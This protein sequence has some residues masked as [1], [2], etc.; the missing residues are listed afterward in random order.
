MGKVNI[1]VSRETENRIEAVCYKTGLSKSDFIRKTAKQCS[2]GKLKPVR[3][4]KIKKSPTKTQILSAK[5]MKEGFIPDELHL[6]A[7]L[8][9]IEK[10]PVR[11]MPK[12]KEIEGVDYNVSESKLWEKFEAGEFK[13]GD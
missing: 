7:A 8:E 3:L 6:I 10:A 4:S 2:S 9:K 12:I 1:R 5:K 13:I 11:K